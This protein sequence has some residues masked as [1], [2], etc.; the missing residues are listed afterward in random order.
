MEKKQSFQTFVILLIIFA[1]GFILRYQYVKDATFPLN[2]GGLFYKMTQELI[3]NEFKLP[4]FTTYNQ[5]L[6]PFAYPPLGFYITGFLSKLLHIPLLQLFL[7]FPFTINL[8]A[9]PVIYLLVK[10][11]TDNREIALFADGFWALALPSYQWLIMGGGVTRSLAFTMSIFS[12]WLFSK[13]SQTGKL[14]TLILASILGGL[15]GLSHLEIF[16]VNVISIIVIWLYKRKNS[17]KRDVLYLLG[18]F[19][20]S[21]VIML[22]YLLTVLNHHGLSPFMAGFHSGE[23]SIV[24]QIVKIILFNFTEEFSV[25]IIAV[26][27]LL[28]IYHQI[29]KR[30]YFYVVWFFLILLLDPRSVNR[31]IILPVSILAA[32][33]LNDIFIPAM[34]KLPL[35]P[36][37]TQIN[38]EHEKKRF[39]SALREIPFQ[40]FFTTLVFIHIFV[41]AF[42]NFFATEQSMDN[43]S[44]DEIKAFDWIN[45]NTSNSST[46]LV[47]SNSIDWQTDQLAE[48]FPAMTDRK[49]LT[50]VQGTEWLPDGRYYDARKFNEAIKDCMVSDYSCI[51][52]ILEE[53]KI[54]ADYVWV[55]K[56]KCENK[57]KICTLPF[58]SNIRYDDNYLLVYENDGVAVFSANNN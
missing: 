23:F 19:F 57:S 37:G 48:W 13:Y 26:F 6:I 27:A 10:E 5:N 14:F 18:Y 35:I 45:E 54:K 52:K 7:W 16:W 11:L 8:V 32:I 3:E 49:S 53:A 43:N 36:N 24:P 21:I 47:L 56:D 17:F 50:T 40:K 39:F 33:V 55:S 20:F 9:I 1:A 42:F 29:R 2:D 4:E 12:L 41:L 46:F 22:P 31:S 44:S 38:I 15:V 58:L 51:P 25:T 34:T 28:G 30:H